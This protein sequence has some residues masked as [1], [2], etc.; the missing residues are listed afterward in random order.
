MNTKDLLL[1]ANMGV[2][3]WEDA[4]VNGVEDVEGSLIPCR[5]KDRWKIVIDLENG[6]IIG[7]PKGTVADVH[8]K[9]C[10]DGKYLITP[11]QGTQI[12]E[13]KGDYVPDSLLC[14]GERGYG[15]YVILKIKDDGKIEG[16]SAPTLDPNDWAITNDGSPASDDPHSSA[17]FNL[18]R[19][20]QGLS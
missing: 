10:D 6:Q 17:V 8:Y 18:H 9:V 16:W 14:I 20:K 13:Y 7:W 5:Q 1:I 12:W 11:K 19:S 15:D 2:R 4:T 3:Y